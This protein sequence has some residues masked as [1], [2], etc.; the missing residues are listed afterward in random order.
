MSDNGDVASFTARLLEETRDE[1]TRADSKASI[2]L[3]GA[4]IALGAVL[5]GFVYGRLSLAASSPGVVAGALFAL[6]LLAA[7]IVLLAVVISP[8]TGEPLEGRARYY[9]DIAAYRDPQE[10]LPVLKREAADTRARNA[11]QL[12]ALSGLVCKKYRL[13]RC[14]LWLLGVGFG[15]AT[16]TASVAAF[17]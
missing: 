7:G 16:F 11:E 1:I 8:T 6:L 17:I 3:A 4:G 5:G 12:H 15:V 13:M 14:A 2:I 9:K 10:L